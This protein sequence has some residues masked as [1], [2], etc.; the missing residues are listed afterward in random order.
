MQFI[1]KN[2]SRRRHNFFI[3]TEYRRSRKSEKE[4]MGEC[5]LNSGKHFAK[6]RTMTFINNKYETFRFHGL[7]VFCLHANFCI[8]FDI[9]HLLNGRNNQGIFRIIAFHLAY[10]SDRIFCFLH[11]IG[12][13]G[14]SP[15]FLER[16]CT[17]FNPIHQEYD[18]IRI[19]R[20]CDKLS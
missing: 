4:R 13:I 16:L 15:I 12:I 10:Q 6:G 1:T 20:S 2:I 9:A 17:K 8:V 7:K 11:V 18:F 14:K 5:R 3:F 19:F